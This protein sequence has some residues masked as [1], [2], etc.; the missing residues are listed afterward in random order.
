[1]NGKKAKLVRRIVKL[2]FTADPREATYTTKHG[3]TT[4]E[5]GCGRQIYQAEKQRRKEYT[6]K[7]TRSNK[8]LKSL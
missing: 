2:A 6:Y 5:V 1:M 3:T 4:L 7:G 8:S